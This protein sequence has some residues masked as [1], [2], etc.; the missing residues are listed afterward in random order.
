MLFTAGKHAEQNRDW[1]NAFP[2][3]SGGCVIQVEFDNN[4]ILTIA[5]AFLRIYLE[6][7][8]K[9]YTKDVMLTVSIQ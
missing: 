5:L 2:G 1:Q 4:Y 8:L 6:T 7:I 9:A 3:F